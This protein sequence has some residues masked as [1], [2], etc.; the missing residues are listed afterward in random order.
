LIANIFGNFFRGQFF[1]GSLVKLIGVL[2]LT[3]LVSNNVFANVI[4]SIE[5]TKADD[6]AL[7]TIRFTTEIQYLRHAPDDEG[8]FLRI[9]F[10]VSK[11]GF[12]EH[13][14]MQE[15]LRSPNS[16]LIPRFSLLYP[17]LLNGMLITFAKTT[18]FSVKPG[19]DTRS[20]LIYVPL[21]PDYKPKATVAAVPEKPVATPL[22]P[23]PASTSKQKVV[24]GTTKVPPIPTPLPA[25]PVAVAPVDAAPVQTPDASKPEATQALSPEKVES[26]AQAF[27]GEAREAFDKADYPKAINRLNR[28]LGL[29]S[30]NQTESA[31]ALMGEAREKNGEVAKARA[32]Y[33]LY[34]KLYPKAPD[35]P[36]IQQRLAGLPSAEQARR[37]GERRRVRDEKPA[38]WMVF[39]SLSSY[40]FTGRS[41]QDSAPFR[42][43]QESLVSS[44][45]LNARL[46]DSVTD[47]RFVF[48]DTDNRNYLQPSRNYN[49]VYAA[50][51]ERTDRE[52]G[53]FVRA[54][55]QNP[56]GGGV[57]ERFDGLTASYNIGS[58]WR[59]SGVVGN[60]VEFNS[61]DKKKF[62][63]GSVELVSQLG[64]PGA[65]LYY[66]EQ[67]IDG[68]LN[69]RA[70]G[71]EFRY[72]DGQFTG[73]GMVDYDV[74]YRGLNIVMGQG[75]YLDKWGNNYF[76][77]YDYRNS[78]SYSLT[79]GLGTT[80]FTTVTDMVNQIGIT[81]SRTLV[82]DN[83][84]V[85]TMFAA[86]V[87]I[88]VGERWQFGTD[89][90]MSS[91][92][93]TN[94]QLPLTQI[95]KSL[96]FSLDPNDPI[97]IGGP[98][99][100]TPVSQLCGA[101]TFD[102]SNNTCKAG[103][104]ASGRTHMYSAQAIGTNLFVPNGV[105]IANFS[106]ISG[107]TYTGQ[108]YGMNYIFPIT[109]SWRMEGNLRYYAQKSDDGQNSS[110]FSPSLKLSHQWLT[111]LFVEGEVGINDS[112]T[113][114]TTASQNR[115]EY[116][117]IGLR[118]DYR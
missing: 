16:E 5:I 118:W 61:P 87:T 75:N 30:N 92:S 63:G 40:F 21:P 77:S 10:K 69:R 7:I 47:T 50:Y 116:L 99:G 58:D 19:G 33:E 79:S 113:S 44:I 49:R 12:A 17:E 104:N 64:R 107:P 37:A 6:K 112:K 108:N 46:R 15:S 54:G 89:Y 11:P 68:F 31:Q 88:P 3:L 9:F 80:G 73:Y 22:S 32:E 70:V 109:E 57:L 18:Q 43:D 14:V 81:Q 41:K 93:G 96:D 83:T 101:N 23:P 60:A 84:A 106:W 102:P 34:L 85:S 95:C 38:E 8:K 62:F 105:G 4:D 1:I 74:L 117:Y 100:D 27:Q 94:V 29:P 36:R 82:S 24:P 76:I 66:I 26:L 51:A 55:R 78:P 72:F 59:V 71:S 35:A 28:I 65:S 67:D 42:R 111:S 114:G 103:Q 13:E 91:I 48:R 25:E 53:Y 52:A 98:R 2:F 86:G 97:C 45:N 90:R 20:I 110:Q 115:R 39:G 56:N